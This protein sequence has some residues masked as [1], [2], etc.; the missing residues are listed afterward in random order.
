MKCPVT[1]DKLFQLIKSWH[2]RLQGRRRCCGYLLWS[3]RITRDFFLQ[4]S[5]FLYLK[6]FLRPQEHDGPQCRTHQKCLRG[7]LEVAFNQLQTEPG[8][9][10]PHLPCQAC[11]ATQWCSTCF[12]D[13]EEDQTPVSRSSNL[14]VNI[15]YTSSSPFSAY[16]IPYQCVLAAPLRWTPCTQILVF[17]GNAT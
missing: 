13:R 14:S 12:P 11:A 16:F 1:V 7:L 9:S 6:G 3:S 17:W 5:V 8:G 4:G 10:I 2:P 15:S